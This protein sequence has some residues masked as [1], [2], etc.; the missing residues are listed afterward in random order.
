MTPR[1]EAA[2]RAQ[3]L[4][5]LENRPYTVWL[6]AVTT[7]REGDEKIDGFY[8]R[9]TPLGGWSGPAADRCVGAIAA[10]A[11]EEAKP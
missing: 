5:R 11:S 9:V 8:A 10:I 7:Y 2:T 4:A 3:D 6:A 1:A